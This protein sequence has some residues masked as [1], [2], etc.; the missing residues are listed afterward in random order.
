MLTSQGIYQRN[1]NF[2][3]VNICIHKTDF[4]NYIINEMCTSSGNNVTREKIIPA[5]RLF[6]P[7][8]Y[9]IEKNLLGYIF[10]EHISE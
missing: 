6:L 2:E 9:T 5:R 8:L 3:C 10:S 1:S 7:R 4:K